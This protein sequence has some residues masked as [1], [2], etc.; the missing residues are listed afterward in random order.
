MAS[1]GLDTML[2][3]AFGAF[4]AIIAATLVACFVFYDHLEPPEKDD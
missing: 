2:N 4:A 1:H 3:E